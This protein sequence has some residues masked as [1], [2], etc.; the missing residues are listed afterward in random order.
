MY[1]SRSNAVR[2]RKRVLLRLAMDLV[3]P[4][5]RSTGAL[6]T[7]ETGIACLELMAF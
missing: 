5:T 4:Q 6:V 1:S 2:T 7:T 3:D